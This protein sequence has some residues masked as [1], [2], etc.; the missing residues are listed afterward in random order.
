MKEYLEK[1]SKQEGRSES[2]LPK[3]DEQ[4]SVQLKGNFV[5]IFVRI[6]SLAVLVILPFLP[7]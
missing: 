3:I 4:W 6:G 1:K 2:R 5:S 7:E